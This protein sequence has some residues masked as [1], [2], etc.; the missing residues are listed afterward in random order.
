MPDL[1]PRV[2]VITGAS[3]G[4]GRATARA[5]AERGADLCLIARG[6]AGLDAARREAEQRGVRAITIPTDVADAQ[7]MLDAAERAESE[8]GPIEAWVNNAMTSVFAPFWEIAPDEFERVTDVTYHGYVNG[9]RA[10]LRH[11]LG[12]DRGVIVMVGSALA[13]RSIP[14]QSAYCGAK[15]AIV[16][17]T[18]S[19]R[20]ELLHE[21]SHVRLTAV[22]L[23][24]HNTPQF[25]WVRSRLPRDAQPVPPIFQPELAA[26]AIVWA[27]EHD[28]REIH[29]AAP[30]ASAILGQK[31][32][33]GLLDRYLV[34]A[35]EGQM[36]DQPLD[37]DRPDN[38]FAPLDDEVDRGAHGEFDDRAR[39]D[40]AYWWF[41]RHRGWLTAAGAGVGA[42]IAAVA[43][44]GLRR[45]SGSNRG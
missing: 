20:S 17:F 18:D 43:S 27:T 23:P 15:H 1:S 13:Y 28:R 25:G 32:A 36:T 39:E 30:T 12:R 11:M 21:G 9:T 6:R 8:L 40:S 42:A 22:H 14:L 4:I 35:W 26:E 44:L 10:A 24:A 33:P 3:A 16:G 37:P 5:F 7:Q 38:L 31:L 2:V 19:L 34:S 41:D 29:L 45:G